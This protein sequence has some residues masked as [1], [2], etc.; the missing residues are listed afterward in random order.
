MVKRVSLALLMIA[1]GCG[2]ETAPVA[3]NESAACCGTLDDT[4]CQEAPHD[5]PAPGARDMATAPVPCPT[6][7][8]WCGGHCVDTASDTDNC[9]ACGVRAQYCSAG[10]PS[11][12]P[13]NATVAYSSVEFGCVDLTKDAQNCGAVGH[14]C[15]NEAPAGKLFYCR[16]G[17]CGGDI[18]VVNTSST[19][20]TCFAEC[21]KLGLNCDDAWFVDDGGHRGGTEFYAYGGFDI[22]GCGAAINP[23]FDGAFARCG[24]IKGDPCGDFVCLA[25]AKI[26][27]VGSTTLRSYPAMGTCSQGVCTFTPS[28][29]ECPHGCINTASG[30][31]C[32]PDPC[33]LVDCHSPPPPTCANATTLRT[34][35]LTGS[36][37]GGTC[38]YAP[39]DQACNSPPSVCYQ[40]TGTCANGACSY[41]YVDGVSCAGGNSVCK[42]GQCTCTPSCAG[43]QC[44]S[45]GCG[46]GCGTCGV[47]TYC[48]TNGTCVA[49][50]CDPVT[51][52]G[53]FPGGCLLFDTDQPSCTR[54]GTGLEGA[55]CYNSL[56]CVGGDGC[57]VNHCRKICDRATG[58]GCESFQKCAPVPGWNNYGTCETM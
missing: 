11:C 10:K 4:R 25:E 18:Q 26:A 37:T 53:C 31:A 47:G 24:C 45:D 54:V 23:T 12:P 9:G 36:C 2:G 40:S 20:T 41:A 8:V 32:N 33:G 28:D 16:A 13:G 22:D 15:A 38:S 39:T 52:T 19:D 46:G 3:C 35:P 56:N 51:N 57:V 42:S 55:A 30:V 44:G 29:T 5:N 48:S 49:N 21:T 7:L 43:K 6:G 17:K 1:A 50:P 14:V 27:C 34:Y 58:A